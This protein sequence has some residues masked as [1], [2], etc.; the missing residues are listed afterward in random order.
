MRVWGEGEAT[1][2]GVSQ[3]AKHPQRSLRAGRKQ[4]R[5]GLRG[6]YPSEHHTPTSGILRAGHRQGREGLRG[7]YP[8]GYTTPSGHCELDTG[9]GGKPPRNVSQRVH[10]PQ[11]ALRA[12]HRQGRE[13]PEGCI[14]AG[15]PPPAGTASWIQVRTGRPPRDV[16]QRGHH[17]Q[18]ALRA[19]HGQGREASEGR[20]PAGAP[21]CAFSGVCVRPAEWGS[22]CALYNKVTELQKMQPRRSKGG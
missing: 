7:M 9:K 18:R 17:P 19:G 22:A 6:M 16:S 15:T 13:A 14:P 2:R 21:R 11:R 20:I 10:H 3:R 5:E 4:G 8:S 1:P 12:G